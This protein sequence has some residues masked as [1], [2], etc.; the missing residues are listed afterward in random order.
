[1]FMPNQQQK[2]A[3]AN[4]VL[5]RRDMERS[6]LEKQGVDPDSLVG[7]FKGLAINPPKLS[8]IRMNLNANKEGNTLE[9]IHALNKFKGGT[10]REDAT[11]FDEQGNLTGMYE[12]EP[13]DQSAKIAA[14]KRLRGNGG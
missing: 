3:E 7:Y 10:I 13:L 9:S 4:D 2:I 12:G 11:T 5:F 6:Q 8:D 14:L 1:M